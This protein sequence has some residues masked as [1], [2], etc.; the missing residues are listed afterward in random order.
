MLRVSYHSKKSLKYKSKE[1][2][3][4]EKVPPSWP[5]VGSLP[6]SL[7]VHIAQTPRFASGENTLLFCHCESKNAL[8][9]KCKQQ[10]HVK[11]KTHISTPHGS[12]VPSHR[13]PRPSPA[14]SHTPANTDPFTET[15]PQ[16]LV[17]ATSLLCCVWSNLLNCHSP[18]SNNECA[19]TSQSHREGDQ[20]YATPLSSH[21]ERPPRTGWQRPFFRFI[22]EDGTALT[23]Y[24]YNFYRQNGKSQTIK[25]WAGWWLPEV[26]GEVGEGGAKVPA[27]RYKI[28]K[29]WGFNVQHSDC[30]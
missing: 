6:T 20:E 26:V 5:T 9:E 21:H 3:N 19:A 11:I 22:H 12:E 28:R 15:E 10:W 24:M 23:P 7:L 2:K 17:I 25:K 30:S 18:N 1:K 4:K 13:Q 14:F 16:R 8:C 27:S 29:P